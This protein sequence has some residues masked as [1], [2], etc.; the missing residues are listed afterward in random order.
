MAKTPHGQRR[1]LS[2]LVAGACATAVLG[3]GLTYPTIA[4]AQVIT[5]GSASADAQSLS[6]RLGSRTKAANARAKVTRKKAKKRR[7]DPVRRDKQAS[8]P[9]P[10][11]ASGGSAGGSGVGSPAMPP[12]GR[13]DLS[14]GDGQRLSVYE[15]RRL[16]L[17]STDVLTAKFPQARAMGVSTMSLDISYVVD[18][19]EI[20]DA[21]TRAV[22]RD[23]YISRLRS[24]VT[25]AGSAGIAVEALAGSPHWI[26]AEVRYVLDIVATFVSEY[27]LAVGVAERLT[28]LHF[29][30][31]PWGTADW[32]AKKQHLTANLLETVQAASQRQLELPA[33]QRLPINFDLPFWLDGTTAPTAVSFG[34]V[35]ASPTEHVMRLA[36]NGAFADGRTRNAVTIMA[37]RDTT[38]GVDG[39][40][41]VVAGEFELA[42]AYAAQVSVVIAQEIG[43]ADP[44]RITFFQEGLPAMTAAIEVLRAEH[45]A[46]PAFGGF[47]IDHMDELSRRL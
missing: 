12:P 42:V 1:R 18:I 3:L 36:A 27:N 29:D 40:L 8:Q 30:L 35:T 25:H 37:Y 9:T 45:G 19:S 24:Y 41:A 47:A 2:L 10:S 17:T 5:A 22:A 32:A 39:S 16:D 4:P 28:G 34:G 26:G 38:G 31:E 14:T 7:N 11:Q 15:W 20:N 43:N 46:S 44:P 13:P 23:S 33:D 21:T 6:E